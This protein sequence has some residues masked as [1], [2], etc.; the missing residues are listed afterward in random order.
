[1]NV[2]ISMDQR[3]E[4]TGYKRHTIVIALVFIFSV[5]NVETSVPVPSPVGDEGSDM[6]FLIRI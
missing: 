3:S 2:P 5:K 4:L 6:V 1:M